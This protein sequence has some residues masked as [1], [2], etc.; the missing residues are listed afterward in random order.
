MAESSTKPYL[1]RAIH[2]WCTDNGFTPYVAVAVDART[3]VPI[4][5]V[6]NNEIVLNV[7]PLATHR[8]HLGNDLI[9]FQARFGGVPRD[10][11]IPV[12]NITAIYAREN[13]LGMAFEVSRVPAQDDSTDPLASGEGTGVDDDAP[14][15]GASP[16]A[17]SG[18]A[19]P[20][21]AAGASPAGPG[22]RREAGRGAKAPQLV[23]VSSIGEEGDERSPGKPRAAA[24]EDAKGEAGTGAEAGASAPDDPDQPDPAPT[25]PRQSRPKLTRIK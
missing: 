13:G 20:A 1:I 6:H 8:L 18:G 2:Q 5:H 16:A 14:G 19:E 21:D 23:A 11:S 17:D 12:E 7:S 25:K 3:R 10:L 15:A 24:P 9:E 4:E 22:K